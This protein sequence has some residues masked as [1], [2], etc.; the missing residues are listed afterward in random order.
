MVKKLHIQIDP[1]NG[2]WGK[3]ISKK[4]ENLTGVKF[5]PGVGLI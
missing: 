4:Q 2:I 5:K 1:F 3:E